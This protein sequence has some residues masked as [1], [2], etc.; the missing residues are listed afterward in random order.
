MSRIR[1]LTP[2]ECLEA[3]KEGYVGKKCTRHL[4]FDRY[5]IT[6]AAISTETKC[7]SIIFEDTRMRLTWVMDFEKF[8][9]EFSLLDENGMPIEKL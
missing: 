4:F 1:A 5:V 6:G 8:K 9:E 3:V 7:L 2:E